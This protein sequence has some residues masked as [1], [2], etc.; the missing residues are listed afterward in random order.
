MKKTL[1]TRNFTI[2]TLGTI[3]S[4][5]GGV[6][7]NLAFG[8][9]VF[10]QTASTWLSSSLIAITYIPSIL[11]PVLIAPYV[12][13]C[14]KRKV[15]VALDYICGILY[16]LFQFYLRGFA[17]SYEM[18][19]LFGF[20]TSSIGTVYNL[21]YTAFYPDLIPEGL[22][23][24]GYTISS[25]IYPTVTALITPVAA[26][27]YVKAGIETI[28]LI[29]GILLLLAA[30]F[31]LLIRPPYEKNEYSETKTEKKTFTENLIAYRNDLLEGFR[32]LKKEKGLRNLYYYSAV[33]NGAAQGIST[34][35]MAA[36]QSSPLL[37]TTMYSLL[38]SAETVGRMIGG[39]IHYFIKIP[40]KMKYKITKSV[41]KIY[42]ICDM[43]LL[44]LPYPVMLVLRFLCGFLGINTATIR[45][46]AVQ[47]YIPANVR[48]RVNAIISTM[49]Y[50]Y[51]MAAQLVAGAL[52][53]I[54]PYKIVTLI[55]AGT[56]FL[57]IY[58]FVVRNKKEIS[59]LLNNVY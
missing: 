23:Q 25:M 42:E 46:A 45:E 14:D 56:T 17:F 38:I 39:V 20:I 48:G 29:E 3:I 40:A 2:I 36:F 9:V 27:L 11:L 43:A 13:H 52:G 28:M 44:F 31:E 18:Y 54:L 6:A 58:L 51:A 8:L 16:L 19:L 35:I 49:I 5:I 32:Y 47:N 34:M 4:S 57:C 37:T 53:E 55:L 30:S 59:P 1:W 15:I 10:D 41:Y 21:T 24:K 50:L 12:D 33:T 26:V 7:M 22:A